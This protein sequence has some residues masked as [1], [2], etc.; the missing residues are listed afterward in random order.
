MDTF[1][2][3]TRFPRIESDSLGWTEITESQEDQEDARHSYA[4]RVHALLCKA[5]AVLSADENPHVLC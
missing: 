3:K 1:E 4:L 2:S 5:R